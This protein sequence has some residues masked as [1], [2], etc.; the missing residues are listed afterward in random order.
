MTHNSRMTTAIVVFVPKPPT[1]EEVWAKL[2]AQAWAK[3]LKR[4]PEKKIYPGAGLCAIKFAVKLM[5]P[6]LRKRMAGTLVKRRPWVGVYREGCAWGANPHFAKP[7]HTKPSAKQ[8]REGMDRV[9]GHMSMDGTC[10]KPT[11]YH[12]DVCGICRALAKCGAQYYKMMEGWD[13]DK[14]WVLTALRAYRIAHGIKKAK[15][16][17]ELRDAKAHLD[18]HFPRRGLYQKVWLKRQRELE[19]VDPVAAP[20]P[21]P[22][23]AEATVAAERAAS[24]VAL[25]KRRKTAPAFTFMTSFL[26]QHAHG[27][28]EAE[29]NDSVFVGA[30][31]D[32]SAAVEVEVAARGAKRAR[33]A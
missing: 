1:A 3:F 21:T 6:I 24:L 11:L 26:A 16:A 2:I 9:L 30:A 33:V 32:N 23:E 25:A 27:P 31:C 20:G 22:E 13:E 5:M 4:S 10:P 17:V 14:P 8:I 19:L 28:Y 29:E 12:G 7:E 18:E 15:N